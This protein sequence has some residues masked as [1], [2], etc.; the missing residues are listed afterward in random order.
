MAI[1][2]AMAAKKP[3]ITTKVGSIP[4][5]ITHEKTGLLV[6]PG[7]I[8]SIETSIKELLNN[9]DKA[10]LF[11]ENGYKTIVNNFS[12]KT[13]ASKYIDIYKLLLHPSFS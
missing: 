11:A 10:V 5:L 4:K 12:S 8:S 7:D 1:L 3:I 13:M 6:E 2:E 9:Q